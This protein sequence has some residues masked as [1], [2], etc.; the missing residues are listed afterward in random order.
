MIVPKH[1]ENLEVLHE[2]TCAPHAYFIP[3]SGEVRDPN[4]D[5][6]SSDR[7][8]LLSGEWDFRFFT[9]I[10][11]ATER[12]YETGADR[13]RFKKV[14]VPGVWQN[15]GYD[16]HQYVNTNYP[17]P[18]DPP[19][20]PKENPCG[21]YLYDFEYTPKS[22]AP[23]VFLNFEGVDSCYY[24]WLNG[25]YVGYSQVTHAIGEFDVTELIHEGRN[26]LAVL[27]LKWCD[28]SYME[29]QDKFRMTGIIRD[30]YLV[31]RPESF[32]RDYR[33]TATPDVTGEAKICLAA[34][35]EGTPVETEVSLYDEE[36]ELVARDLLNE[37]GSCTFAVADARLWSAETPYLYRVVIANA[38]ETIVDELG[39]RKIEARDGV[40]RVNGVAIKIHGTNRHDSDP[41]TGPVIS[42]EQLKKDLVL[43]KQHNINAIRTS[44]YPNSPWAYYYYERLGFYVIDEA[45]NES[46]GADMCYRADK[47]W[48][49][50]RKT[51]SERL[52]DNPD[53]TPATVDRARLLVT[54]D[55]NRSCV[56]MWSMGNECAYGCTFEA[57]LRW[58][59]EYDSTRLTHYESAFYT[60]DRRKYN[61]NDLDTY[62]RM[63][64]SLEDMEDYLENDQRKPYVL[65]E[66]CHA[67]GNGPGDLEDYFQLIHRY[68][69]ACGGMI[70]EWCDHAVLQGKTADGLVRYGYGGDSGEKL[71]DGNFCMDGLVYPDRRVHTGLLEFKNVHRPARILSYSEKSGSLTLRNFMDFRNLSDY[72]KIEYRLEC[73]GSVVSEG[74]LSQL[75]CPAHEKVTV[76]LPLTIPAQGKCYLKLVYRLLHD[77]GVLPAGF[78]LGREELL[79]QN[80][81]GRYMDAVR[82]SDF[83]AKAIDDFSVEEGERYIR[84]S[85]DSYDY[86]YDK[87][88]GAF[89]E[90]ACRGRKLLTAP[91]EWNVW[92]APT[93]N[94]ANVKGEW[95]EAGYEESVTRT[96]DTEITVQQT[97]IRIETTLSLS[98][99]HIQ[100]FVRGKVCWTIYEDGKIGMRLEATRDTEFPMLPRFGLRLH[101]PEEM[102]RVAYYGMGP[103]ESYI[104]KHRASEH[105]LFITSVEDL[106][107]DYIRPQENGSHYDC[108][109][110][111]V[112]DEYSQL[113]VAG[114]N[115]FSFNASYYT[116]E[117]LTRADHNYE[118][119]KSGE[120]IL[121]LDYKQNGIGSNSC[122]PSL[123][124]KYRFD[125]GEFT[126][127][128]AFECT[129]K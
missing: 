72:V 10:A 80:E 48:D 19:Y 76:S 94:D 110:V 50:H 78:E 5:R 114:V 123:Q 56:I 65:C 103:Y 111:S 68:E 16:G 70:W 104:D 17:F 51:W 124:E 35:W 102:N 11:E 87:D 100:P 73:D 52:A 96:Y 55:K 101:M 79:L 88:A 53:W 2:N 28:G 127:E 45:D 113:T 86:C 77:D 82:I 15:Y 6:T 95:R 119:K 34:E 129:V 9:G 23:K 36:G 97:C 128:L 116:E 126:Y 29:D 3:A 42:Q 14:A 20:V 105:G 41:V 46:H 7:F 108:N 58:T 75:D 1:F 24:V 61:F 26:T 66:Y 32:I 18:L 44:H 27:V 25:T 81:D 67:M 64:P 74:T 84:I 37:K 30:V 47:S 43:M 4:V 90:M 89:A 115:G 118:L 12:F 8:T 21:E 69:C 92:R 93:D 120:T 22:D 31:E 38:G 121:C 59:K 112:N 122:G 49:H 54:R 107:E 117:E 71:H 40:L 83:P 106:H 33:L 91:M 63:Y 60:S 98:A 62:S 39:V 85:N 57:A 109:M 125:E 13:S 99:I